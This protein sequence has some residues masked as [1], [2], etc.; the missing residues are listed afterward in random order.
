LQ[1]NKCSGDRCAH[2]RTYDSGGGRK[3]KRVSVSAVQ[4]LGELVFGEKVAV[5]GGAA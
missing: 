5:Q 4:R 3:V 1:A 2:D